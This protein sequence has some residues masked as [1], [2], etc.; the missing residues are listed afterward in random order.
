MWGDDVAI[1]NDNDPTT[2]GRPFF[3]SANLLLNCLYYQDLRAVAEL[4]RRLHRPAD[5]K[6]LEAKA[7]QQGMHIQELCWDPRDKFYYTVDVQC[8]D[9]R[10]ELIPN[11]K[12]GIPMSWHSLPLCIQ[13]FTGFLPLWCG[14]ERRNRRAC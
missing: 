1:G 11:V 4:A 14:L 2:F 3:S 6:R 7:K 10:S 9:R 13:T 5:Q 12:P 8:V